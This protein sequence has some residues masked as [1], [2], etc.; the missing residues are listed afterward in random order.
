MLVGAQTAQIGEFLR[1]RVMNAAAECPDMLGALQHSTIPIDRAPSTGS[2][3]AN[4]DLHRRQCL[5]QKMVRS[6]R[7]IREKSR[8]WQIH[9]HLHCLRSWCCRAGGIANPHTLDLLLYRSIT[10]CLLPCKPGITFD[11][12]VDVHILPGCV[13]PPI[14]RARPDA[15]NTD[16]RLVNCMNEWLLP[17]SDHR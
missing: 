6:E 5:A 12:S 15:A 7:C 4:V 14:W 11:D 9:W 13:Q 16:V 2:P 1:M 10:V 17:Y 8:C 3:Y